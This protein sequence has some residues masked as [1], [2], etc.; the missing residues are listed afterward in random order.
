MTR[1]FSFSFEFKVRRL[2]MKKS[3]GPQ[4]V[5]YP[6]P[7]FV[8]GT[9]DQQGKPNIMTVAWSGFCCSTPP[10]ISIAVRQTAYTYNNLMNQ[11][12]FTVS[13]AR[14]IQAKIVDY[15]GIASGRKHDKFAGAGLTVG[16]SDTVNAP[17]VKE[18][19]LVLECKVVHIKKL[20]VHTL[21]VGEILDI[22]ADEEVLGDDGVPD[23]TKVDP[24]I[25]APGN[26]LYFGLGKS[27]GPSHS[28]GKELLKRN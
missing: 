25:W 8:V 27:I 5:A 17:Y 16:R 7:A 22:K 10:C 2:E 3:I 9:Y 20:G 21:F 28:M 18:F 12:A 19:P 13:V 24:L 4:N 23:P 11:K 15:I 6:A 1:G 14:R 26:R